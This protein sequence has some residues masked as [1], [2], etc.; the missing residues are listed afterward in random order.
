MS[1]SGIPPPEIIRPKNLSVSSTSGSSLM[2]ISI[3]VSVLPGENVMG[4]A[5]A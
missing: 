4:N 1:R 5:L 3:I 2:G